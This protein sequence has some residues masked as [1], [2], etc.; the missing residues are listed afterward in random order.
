VTQ[1]HLLSAIKSGYACGQVLESLEQ[2][3]FDLSTVR[4]AGEEET[5][6]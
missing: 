3:G 5:A 1:E 4:E 2:Q 6:P